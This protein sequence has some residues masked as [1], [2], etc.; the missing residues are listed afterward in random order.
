VNR[1][2]IIF[3]LGAFLSGFL[4]TQAV[5]ETKSL[6]RF[7]AVDIY[8]DSKGEPLAAYQL[9][10][11]SQDRTA[12]IVGIEGGENSVF[13]DPPYYDP[14]AIQQER[15]ILAAFS[16]AKEERLP[17]GKIRVATIHLQISGSHSLEPLLKNARMANPGGR[18]I[19]VTATCLERQVELQ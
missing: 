19:K 5:D 16:T 2:K 12:K 8:L 3:W 4:C 11:A 1:C 9:E 18:K 6:V 13:K 17:K 10:W 15:V 7:K 14:K